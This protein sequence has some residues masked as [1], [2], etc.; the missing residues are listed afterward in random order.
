M[1]NPVCHE[2]FFTLGD[3]AA[4]NRKTDG[5]N[6]GLPTGI[7][8]NYVCVEL[9]TGS[10]PCRVVAHIVVSGKPVELKAKWVRGPPTHGG[11]GALI[12]RGD[13][14]IPIETDLF[15]AAR[16]DTG[17]ELKFSLH[18]ITEVDVVA[19]TP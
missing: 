6:P 16:N 12:W 5:A 10:A 19:V 15:I 11:A 1:V 7:R 9:P 13:I 18:W 3:N 2:R 14:P 8:L 17:V 4:T